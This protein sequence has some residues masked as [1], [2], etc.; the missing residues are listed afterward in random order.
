MNN[1]IGI[2]VSKDKLDVFELVGLEHHQ[3]ENNSRGLK[4]LQKLIA[5]LG[6]SLVIF[7]ASGVYHREL[8][9]SLAKNAVPYTKVNPRQAR[10]F[11]EATGKIRPCVTWLSTSIRFSSRSLMIINPTATLQSCFNREV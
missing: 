5:K 4:M 11:S 1:T 3:V 9:T 2:D 7:E 6:A 10:R 8:E